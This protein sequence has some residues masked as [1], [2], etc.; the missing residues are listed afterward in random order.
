MIMAQT[1]SDTPPFSTTQPQAMNGQDHSASTVGLLRR[2]GEDLTTLLRKELA[3]ATGEISRSVDDAKRGISSI[4]TGG[5]VL[6]A[7]FIVLLLA[8]AAALAE[9]MEPWL[10]GLIVG[11]VV[12][13]IGYLMVSFGR[14][15]MQHSMRTP[16]RTAASLREDR[17]LFHRRRQ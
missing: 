9:V 15:R 3:L 17:E 7:G 12:C 8:A 6:L 4:A 16:E 1:T 14:K 2:L 5:A 10:A 11:A 13:I